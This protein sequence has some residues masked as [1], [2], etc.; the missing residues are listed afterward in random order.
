MAQQQTSE[1]GV[2]PINTPVYWPAER[3]TCHGRVV[4]THAGHYRLVCD[5][6]K[7]HPGVFAHKGVV[8]SGGVLEVPVGQV[9]LDRRAR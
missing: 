3:P 6:A 8:A 1:T 4:G 5:A 2:F 9:A 7:H